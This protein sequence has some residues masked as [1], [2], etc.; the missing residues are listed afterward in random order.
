M[1]ER[2]ICV[3]V[4]IPIYNMDEYLKEC[5][6]SVMAQTLKK[7]E[8]VCIND[9]STDDT[10][11]ILREYA[12]ND[13]RIRILDTENCGPGPARNL[14]IKESKGKYVAFMDADDYYPEP[15]VLEALYFSAE[16][17]SAYISGGEFSIIRPDGTIEHAE[18][19]KDDPFLFGYYFEKEGFV[20]YRDY[21]FDYGF[22]R[23]IYNREFLVKNEL[24][25]PNLL[26]F[27]DPP[28]MVQALAQAKRFYAIKKETYRYRTADK[29]GSWSINKI[30]DLFRGLLINL[31]YAEKESLDRLY[32]LTS[33]R[34]TKEYRFALEKLSAF[35]KDEQDENVGYIDRYEGL[36]KLYN[37]QHKEMDE[38]KRSIS[39]R[40]GLLVTYVPR[41]ILNACRKMGLSSKD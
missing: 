24:F 26:R 14:G 30:S 7:I 25:F 20:D 33:Q 17:N 39:Y 34:I 22:H 21:Q 11:K 12:K 13:S 6:D 4:I 3:S 41:A 10:S 32:K 1:S 38:V 31:E 28:F 19:F 9:G 8:I 40:V 23:F 2:D 35:L 16:D 5:L 15:D 29:T 27:Q 36:M 18:A 37:Q